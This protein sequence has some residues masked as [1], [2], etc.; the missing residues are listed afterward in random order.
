[1]LYQK[2]GNIDQ[3]LVDDHCNDW[4]HLLSEVNRVPPL[5]IV[6]TDMTS[7]NELIPFFVRFSFDLFLTIA[8]KFSHVVVALSLYFLS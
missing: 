6:R 7:F 8:A 4:E 5:E 1:M 2:D 3:Q